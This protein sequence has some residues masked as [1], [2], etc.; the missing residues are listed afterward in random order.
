MELHSKNILALYTPTY[1]KLEHR[2][3]N[4]AEVISYFL[5]KGVLILYTPQNMTSS[6]VPVL[7]VLLVGLTWAASASPNKKYSLLG[8]AM[9]SPANRG[10]RLK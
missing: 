9:G 7:V 2:S 10:G 4:Q 3:L 8:R 1:I 5:C 6:F